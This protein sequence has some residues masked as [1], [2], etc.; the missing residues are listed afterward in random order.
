M[1]DDINNSMNY[2]NGTSEVNEAKKLMNLL[3]IVR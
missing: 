3:K 2:S 1:S